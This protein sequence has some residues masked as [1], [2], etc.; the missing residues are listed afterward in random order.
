MATGSTIV[1]SIEAETKL[2]IE[3]DSILLLHY[4]IMVRL[5][6]GVRSKSKHIY[7]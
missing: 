6:L 1:Q 2:F 5:D 3:V 7:S 4:R